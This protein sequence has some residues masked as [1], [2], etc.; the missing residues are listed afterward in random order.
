[1]NQKSKSGN[2]I[3]K[4]TTTKK[5]LKKSKNLTKAS[6]TSKRVISKGT[7]ASRIKKT[8][9]KVCPKWEIKYPERCSNTIKDGASTLYFCTKK[10]KDRYEKAP[11]KF[12]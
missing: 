4:K 7:S 8:F 5:I 6:A 3:P 2:S 9:C 12:S 10:C 11:E 1:M